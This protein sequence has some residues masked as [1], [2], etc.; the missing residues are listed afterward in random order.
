M[1]KCVRYKDFT[2]TIR[3]RVYE[4]VLTEHLTPGE[5]ERE[6]KRESKSNLRE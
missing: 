3:L 5:R 2:G 1:N 4:Q 6:S